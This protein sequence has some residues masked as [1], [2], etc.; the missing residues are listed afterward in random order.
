M[1]L[2]LE[3]NAHSLPYIRVPFTKMATRIELI[4]SREFWA[5]VES[6]EPQ[7]VFSQTRF[8]T[9]DGRAEQWKKMECTRS[10]EAGLETSR[11]CR[12]QTVY[13]LFHGNSDVVVHV[14]VCP[15]VKHPLRKHPMVEGSVG[16]G[17]ENFREH[18]KCPLIFLRQ[19]PS[20]EKRT[21]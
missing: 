7:G 4:N 10:R 1:E 21:T 18:P 12:F 3:Q 14:H 2:K 9:G 17:A 16:T 11:S 13:S 20:M 5:Q 15:Q 6:E 8:P 19:H